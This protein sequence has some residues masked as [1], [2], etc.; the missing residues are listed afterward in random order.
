MEARDNST[1]IIAQ[2]EEK[3]QQTEN[4]KRR[5]FVS[6]PYKDNPLGNKIKVEEICR[7][8]TDEGVLPISPVHLFGF[9]DNDDS[10]EDILQWCF[11]MIELCDEVWVYGKSAGCM[12]E[13]QHAESIGKPV[14]I[15]Y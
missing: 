3:S 9:M 4:R 1:M 7:N 13:K 6:H 2:T 8:L 15:L 12:A 11:D 5:I 10:R 14:R